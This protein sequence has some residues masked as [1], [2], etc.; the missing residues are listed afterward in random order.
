VRYQDQ[1]Q[2]WYWLLARK[3][4][5]ED[6]NLKAAGRGI[7]R[8]KLIPFAGLVILCVLTAG[9]DKCGQPVKINLPSLPGTCYDNPQQK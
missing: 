4:Q 2:I 5:Q 7:M 8:R 1:P 6:T 9:C 3:C